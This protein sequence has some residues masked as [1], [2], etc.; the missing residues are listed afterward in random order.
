MPLV[1]ILALIVILLLPVQMR[2]GAAGAH[3]HAL[4]HLVLDA[5]DGSFDHHHAEH[6]AAYDGADH[7]D[8]SHT[9]DEHAPDLPTAGESNRVGG[10]L[11]ILAA[12][13]V[14]YAIP[15]TRSSLRW[16]LP[17]RWQGIAR[18]LEPPPPRAGST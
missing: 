16:P 15:I 12:L 3:P 13:V 18:A 17:P 6:D 8:A 9:A 4:L 10:G 2:A 11:A 5:R 1:R 7:G 14:L